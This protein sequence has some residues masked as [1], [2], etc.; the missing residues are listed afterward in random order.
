MITRKQMLE[1]IQKIGDL[2][3]IKIRFMKRGG[4]GELREMRFMTGVKKGLSP[5]P[6]KPGTDFNRHLLL[7]VWDVE[8]DAYR[9]IPIDGVTEILINDQ[10]IKVV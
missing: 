7:G 9:S 10:W 2:I 3:E 4:K 1:H 8:K 5:A 6:T